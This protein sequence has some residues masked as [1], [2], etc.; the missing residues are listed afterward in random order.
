MEGE[1]RHLESRQQN[2]E[3]RLMNQRNHVFE[4][5]SRGDIGNWSEGKLLDSREKEYWTE[6]LFFCKKRKRQF[7]KKISKMSVPKIKSNSPPSLPIY[8][9]LC[10]NAPISLAHSNDETMPCHA[11]PKRKRKRKM[12]IS[13][14]KP[15]K[16]RSGRVRRCRSQRP[17][18][19]YPPGPATTPRCNGGRTK[20]WPVP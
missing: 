7:E 2:R 12:A 9:N 20:I 8:S 19:R 6:K 5:K 11:P 16:H 13:S 10:L 15:H 3:K 18:S 17:S 1:Q 4:K 14:K